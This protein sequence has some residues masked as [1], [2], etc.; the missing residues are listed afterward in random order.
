MAG[1]FDPSICPICGKSFCPAPEHSLTDCKGNFVCSCH[2]ST[3]AYERRYG[4][5][6]IDD[7]RQ[8]EKEREQYRERYWR[9]RR[10]AGGEK[11]ERK[12]RFM[13]PVC[14]IRKDDGVI[15]ARYPSVK[16]AAEATGFYPSTVSQICSGTQTTVGVYTFRYAENGDEVQEGQ[17]F[18]LKRKPPKAVMQFTMKG[19]FV[20]RYDSITIAERATGC[21]KGSV[22]LCCRHKQIQS[23]GFIFM[24]ES[25]F[26]EFDKRVKDESLMEYV[27]SNKATPK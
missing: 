22:S 13:R 1:Y 8:I 27:V 14:V 16:A 15:M 26:D 6:K 9:D 19:E 25:E 23:K 3:V 24:F 2:C 5:K 10:E 17:S 7:E 18:A 20:A 12:P 4:G 11:V 21:A